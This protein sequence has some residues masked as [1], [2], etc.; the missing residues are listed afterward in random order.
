MRCIIVDDEAPARSELRFFIENA[1]RI[2]VV[3]EFDNALEALDFLGRENVETIFLDIHMP[4]LDGMALSKVLNR[5]DCKAE[6]VFV[7]AHQEYA[8]EAF[9]VE[10]FDY[11][12]KPYSEERMIRTLKKLEECFES[13]HTKDKITLWKHD[14]MVVV[15]VDEIRY[16][17]ASERTTIVYTN[18]DHFVVSSNITDFYGKL[19]QGT[20][21]R[22]HRSYVM[23]M[24]HIDEIIPW[25]NNTY[26]VK[27]KGLEE[28]VPVSRNNMKAFKRNMRI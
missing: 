3:Q 15:C 20:F 9:D 21:F 10:A 25:F 4:N 13:Q 7:T 28:Q 24:N 23:N 8:I 5:S 2:E 17:K 19:P 18:H 1:S 14:K 16:C 27:F 11:I 12:L 26:V 22:S 6:I